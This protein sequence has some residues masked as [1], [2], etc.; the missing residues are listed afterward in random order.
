[1]AFRKFTVQR[2]PDKKQTKTNIKYSPGGVLS[3]SP[4]KLG[5]YD[6]SGQCLSGGPYR[7]C[8]SWTFR[9]RRTVSSRGAL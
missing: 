5:M 4:T 9:I 6:D 3:T 2:L 7:S 1:V 8:T